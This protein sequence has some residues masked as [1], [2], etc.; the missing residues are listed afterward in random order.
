M[1]MEESTD[2]QNDTRHNEADR[3]SVKAPPLSLLFSSDFDKDSGDLW[4]TT[5]GQTIYG[6][7][8]R[9]LTLTMSINEN[10]FALSL[11]FVQVCKLENSLQTDWKT[12]TKTIRI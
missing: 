6:R 4:E 2:R 10:F 5:G 7:E 9:M 3:Q 12:E 1:P 8:P 11:Y